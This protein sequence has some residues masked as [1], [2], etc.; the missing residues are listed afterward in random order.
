MSS[1]RKLETY[2]RMLCSDGSYMNTASDG[3]LYVSMTANSAGSGSLETTQKSVLLSSQNC[4]TSLSSLAG[5]DFAT[6]TSLSN[7][8][9]K[10]PASV[11]SKASASSFSVTLAN[12]EPSVDVKS[13][14]VFLASE[15]TLVSIKDAVEGTLNVSGSL[16]SSPI[17][18]TPYF[19]NSVRPTA[20]EV[21]VGACSL[22]DINIGNAVNG[23]ACVA[24]YDKAT[25]ALSSDTPVYVAYVMTYS[26]TAYRLS[27]NLDFVN[28]ISIRGINGWDHTGS[29]DPGASGLA[30]SLLYSV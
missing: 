4:E 1:S 17:S 2:S 11:G 29:G 9:S 25:A 30:I 16:T 21:Y 14:D 3:S 10:F 5:F 24:F 15:S 6:Q 18:L 12:D 19:N 27:G 8:S 7:L 20:S 23:R 13:N 28:G 26:Q 22:R